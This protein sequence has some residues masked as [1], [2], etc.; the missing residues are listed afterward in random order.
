MIAVT[1]A[2]L[3]AIHLLAAVNFSQMDLQEIKQTDWYKERPLV[4]QQAIDLL[5]PTQLY[6]F[7]ESGKQCQLRSYEEPESGKLEDVTVTVVKTG[8]GGALEGTGLE[9]LM[10]ANIG[11]FGVKLDTLEPWGA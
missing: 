11:V 10:D 2:P 5:P 9:M 4:I 8:V 7:K 3:L 6:K 1:S